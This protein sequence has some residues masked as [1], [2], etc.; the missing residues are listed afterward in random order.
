AARGFTIG[1]AILMREARK[2]QKKVI[3]V[4]TGVMTARALEAAELLASQDIEC[5]VV[6]MH[7]VKPLDE[8][9]LVE[10]VKGAESLF[11]IEEHTVIAGLGSAVIECL[12]E[13]LPGS[14]LFMRKLGLPDKF[15]V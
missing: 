6:H 8:D 13:R 14:P 2:S 1:K 15:A 7:T 9:M 4:S 10:R 11:T 5:D 12:V 3:L